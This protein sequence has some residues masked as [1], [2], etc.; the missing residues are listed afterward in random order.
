MAAD[1]ALP[2]RPSTPAVWHAS[3]LPFSRDSVADTNRKPGSVPEE[4]WGMKGWRDLCVTFG[5]AGLSVPPIPKAQR[6]ELSLIYKWCWSTRADIAPGRMYMF[7]YANEILAGPVSEYTA[8]SHAG[9]GINS[10]GLNVSIVKAPLALLFQHSWGGAYSNPT[11][12]L[13]R[14]AACFSFMRSLVTSA[15][16]DRAEERGLRH[17]IA[18]SSFRGIADHYTRADSGAW[19]KQLDEDRHPKVRLDADDRRDIDR[20]AESLDAACA[21]FLDYLTMTCN[22]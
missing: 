1:A 11:T 3:L 15:E 17:L 2:S 21:R 20:E 12:E 19:V 18:W 6:T 9:H 7:A 8:V 14:I 22:S 5:D 13:V 16:S 10:Y 4:T